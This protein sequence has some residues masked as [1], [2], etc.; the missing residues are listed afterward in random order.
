MK[1]GLGG[2]TFRVGISTRTAASALVRT[3]REPVGAENA[4]YAVV[5]TI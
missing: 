5:T 3:V 1:M 2:G 4:V